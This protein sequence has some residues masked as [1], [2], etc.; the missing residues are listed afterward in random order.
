MSISK[1]LIL[2]GALTLISLLT[3]CDDS[4]STAG[5]TWEPAT[6]EPAQTSF[7][8]AGP[9]ASSTTTSSTVASHNVP[10]GSVVLSKHTVH[11]QGARG[12]ASHTLL[13]PSDWKKDLQ[14]E[15]R[16]QMQMG[17][18]NLVG[19]VKAQ[20]Q[21]EARFHRMEAYS[22][23]QSSMAANQPTARR[24]DNAGGRIWMRPPSSPAA[25][26]TEVLLPKARP[27]ARGAQIIH[28]EEV[29]S[30]AQTWRNMFAESIRQQEQLNAMN[31]G[32]GGGTQSKTHIAVPRVRVR[33]E[34]GGQRYEEEFT[35]VFFGIF[36][37]MRM[38]G[39][40]FSGADW[41]V[42]DVRSVRAPA[43]QLDKARP[44]LRTILHSVRMTE[45]WHAMYRSLMAYIIKM[46]QKAHAITMEG[47]R[48]RSEI[49]AKSGDDIRAIYSKT[50][51]DTQASNDRIGRAWSNTMRGVDDFKLPDGTT[52]QLDS[53]YDHVYTNGNDQFIFTNDSLY[54]PN[55]GS[56]QD[57]TK[58]KPIAPTG[59]AAWR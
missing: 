12:I 44:M 42:S 59:A 21:R 56:T 18:V 13:A 40:S 52:R 34:E 7:W 54:Q 26:A 51:K 35:F 20:D 9:G 31:R 48:K 10:K 15:W 41:S 8:L 39:M 46:R 4:G 14:V 47:I 30:V 33:Y 5:W 32:M 19:G 37:S 43:G 16:P 3:A 38:N 45:Q 29:K 55:V 28:I 57:W 24:G 1:T 25:Y 53:S 27:G 49:I 22:W 6:S 11:D 17:F 23:Y 58:L 2:S 36:T 50:Y